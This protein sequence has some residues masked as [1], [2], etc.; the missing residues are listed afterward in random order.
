MDFKKK[1]NLAFKLAIILAVL[2]STALTLS[3]RWCF[4]SADGYFVK[5]APPIIFSIV[6]FAGIILPLATVFAF[7]KNHIIKTKNEIGKTQIPYIAIAALLALSVLACNLLSD[8]TLSSIGS[9][10]VGV[11]LIYAILCSVKSGY[12]KSAFKILLIYISVT[13]PIS[14]IFAND[15]NYLRHMNSVENTLTTVFALSFMSYI[16]YEAKRIHEGTHSRWHFGLMLLTFHSG[17]S[18]SI[19]YIIAFLTKSV[20]EPQRFLQMIP[21]FLIS[22]FVGFELLRFINEAEAYTQEEWDE[23]EKPNEEI[24]EEEIIKEETTEE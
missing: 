15:T 16:L 14:M 4:N 6:Y 9:L 22:L 10:G 12:D 24:I 7:N 17:F 19:S 18:F 13:F 5:S 20:D 8:D 11:F 1:I 2:S 23:I 21:V 3:F